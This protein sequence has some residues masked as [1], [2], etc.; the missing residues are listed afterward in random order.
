M[1]DPAFRRGLP[2]TCTPIPSGFTLIELLVVIGIIALLAAILFPVFA[3]ARGKARQAACLSNLRQIGTATQMYASD[4]DGFFPYAK[5]A[6]DANLPQI[7]P[8]ACQPIIR[9]MP[10]LHPVP[11]AGSDEG[12][13]A[14]YI[15]NREVWHC[16]ADSGF[17][18]LDNNDSC[19]GPCPLP[20]RPTMYERYGA[21]YLYRT[22]FAFRQ[23]NVDTVT[24]RGSRTGRELGPSALMYL[25]DGNGSWHGS[26]FR[27]GRSGLRYDCL[28]ADGHVKSL[29][30]EE[31]QDAWQATL[32]TGGGSPCP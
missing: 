20:A 1:Q 8:A 3:A 17:E 27:L 26:P 7:W 32:G 14:T 23:I 5:D 29:A 21:S 18:V 22:E 28:F 30:N 25:F 16:P 10:Y 9:T 2:R 19:G 6:S 13:L 12:A 31:Y 4:Y 15:R 24:A 11:G